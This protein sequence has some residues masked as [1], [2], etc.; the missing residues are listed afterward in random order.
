LITIVAIASQPRHGVSLRKSIMDMCV[1]VPAR[2][3][4]M[5]KAALAKAHAAV[6]P[7][8][9]EIHRRFDAPE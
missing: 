8:S 5:K 2:A 9:Y 7:P 6:R 1:C 4:L 3:G